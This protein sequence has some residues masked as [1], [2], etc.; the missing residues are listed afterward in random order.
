[1]TGNFAATFRGASTDGTMAFFTT[2]E[3]LDG[4]DDR[5]PARHL[6]ARPRRRRHHPRS[7]CRASVRRQP[8]AAPPTA[9]SP[10]TAPTPTSRPANDWSEPTKTTP[11]MSTTGRS[12]EVPPSSRPPPAPGTASRAAIFAGASFDA[13]RVYFETDESLLAAD[14]DEATDVYERSGGTTSLV[15]IGPAGGNGDVG[16]LAGMAFAG[17]QHR[18]RAFRNRGGPGLG[19]RRRIPGRLR[20]QRRHPVAPF[21][22]RDGRKRP[23]QL[24]LRRSL[25]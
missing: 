21:P 6:P 9:G 17:R 15:S 4:A 20:A 23:L 16:R 8:T 2:D 19:R 22:C 5:Q 11:R 14:E 24:E 18:H 1:M 3:Q 25:E 7:R 13:A 12:G 10:P